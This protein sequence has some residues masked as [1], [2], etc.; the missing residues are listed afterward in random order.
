[1]NIDIT[2]TITAVI[3]VSSFLSPIAVAL[4]N[5]HHNAKLRHMELLH[6]ENIRWLDIQKE[7]ASHQFDVY[8]SDKKAAFSKI[9]ISSG[10]FSLLCKSVDRYHALHSAIDEALLYCNPQNYYLL[11]NFQHYVTHE[12]FGKNLSSYDLDSYNETLAS[13]LSSLNEELL[14]TQPV[15]KRE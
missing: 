7:T 1:M 12:V 2:W 15:I 13:L 3:A 11:K 8:Y 5:N 9:A 4:I 14:S 10:E 6:D